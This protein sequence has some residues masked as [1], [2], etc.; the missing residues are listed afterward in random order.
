MNALAFCDCK[1]QE[2]IQT[3]TVY[4][5]DGELV[6]GHCRHYPVY[7]PTKAT[8]DAL[9]WRAEFSRDLQE[10]LATWDTGDATE[11]PDL[12]GYWERKNAG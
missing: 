2:L 7:V 9:N 11:T 10:L 6:C 5:I 4:N 12:A 3:K 8:S 1:T